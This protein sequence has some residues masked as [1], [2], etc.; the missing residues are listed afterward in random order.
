MTPDSTAS[1]AS[2]ATH[3]QKPS[4]ITVGAPPSVC[5]AGM[6]AANVRPV[7]TPDMTDNSIAL[8]NPPT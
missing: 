8:S 5:A 2:M 7:T 1:M 3:C 6:I 4:P